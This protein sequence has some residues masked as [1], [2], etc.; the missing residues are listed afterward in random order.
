MR[1]FSI[2]DR[3][4]VWRRGYDVLA[5]GHM[6]LAAD[7]RVSVEKHSG[8]NTLNI[9]D[10]TETD[11]GEYVCQVLQN[12]VN[13]L[14]VPCVS[15]GISSPDEYLLFQI[16]LLNDILSV[17]HTLDVLGMYNEYFSHESI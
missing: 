14:Y 12:R 2:G 16:S 13:I 10:I 15:I 7:P 6:V 9:R 17:Q 3:H 1:S 4:I 5:T 11:A 8:V